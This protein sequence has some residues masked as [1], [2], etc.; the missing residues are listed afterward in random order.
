MFWRSKKSTVKTAGAPTVTS[1][2]ASE[3]NNPTPLSWF[4]GEN[5]EM[6]AAIAEAQS[7]FPDFIEV[8]AGQSNDGT[9][10]LDVALVKY[11]F[12]ATKAGAV[13]EHVFLGD[14]YSKG[15]VLWG[16]VNDNPLYTDEVSE[17]DEVIIDRE[18][19]SDWLYVVE[20]KGIG[21]FTFKLMWN[22]FSAQEKT[23]YGLQPPFVWLAHQL[24]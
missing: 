11:A 2:D 18:R 7:S 17:G 3:N 5:P 13:V 12:A 1:K 23:A 8:I 9:P 20:G 4:G 10:S 24:P 16:V 6:N 22:N 14:V 15:G 21:G 19:V